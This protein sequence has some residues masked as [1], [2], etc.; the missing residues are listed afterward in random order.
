MDERR[1][2]PRSDQGLSTPS[3]PPNGVITGGGGR[4]LAQRCA[5]GEQ[6][7]PG[8]RMSDA[9]AVHPP[10]CGRRKF[11]EEDMAVMVKQRRERPLRLNTLVARVLS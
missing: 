7:Q 9:R 2:V 4:P 5:R 10:E 11:V 1:T 6:I 3:A 8:A